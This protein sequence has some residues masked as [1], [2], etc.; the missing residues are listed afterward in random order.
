MLRIVF[1][2]NTSRRTISSLLTSS[3]PVLRRNSL[4][5]LSYVTTLFTNV[6]LSMTLSSDALDDVVRTFLQLRH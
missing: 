5:D 2:S 6:P 3:H 1:P 4:L